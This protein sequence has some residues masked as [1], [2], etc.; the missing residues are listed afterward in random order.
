MVASDGVERKAV[1]QQ[2]GGVGFQLGQRCSSC[3]QQAARRAQFTCEAALV[4]TDLDLAIDVGDIVGPGQ[5]APGHA[6]CIV[7]SPPDTIFSKPIRSMKP[8]RLAN[9][10]RVHGR[11]RGWLRPAS[12]R[13]WRRAWRRHWRWT[14]VQPPAAAAGWC[15]AP[16]IRPGFPVEQE[17]FGLQ[18][19]GGNV[20]QIAVRGQGLVGL[21][22]VVLAAQRQVLQARGDLAGDGAGCLAPLQRTGRLARLDV[23]APLR[24]IRTVA[25]RVRSLSV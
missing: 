1:A 20:G 9:D 25:Y 15:P 12:S 22:A 17:L 7:P 5:V 23:H 13:P 6:A 21:V 3:R 19:D 4:D 11:S 18:I 24:R 2:A 14:L 16:A 8:P 10:R